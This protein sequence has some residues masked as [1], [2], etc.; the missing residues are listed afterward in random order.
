MTYLTL[1]AGTNASIHKQ[2][3]DELITQEKGISEF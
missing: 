3:D 1:R 2:N